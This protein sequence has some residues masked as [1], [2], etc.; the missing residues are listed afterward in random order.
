MTEIPRLS[1][2][3]K[4]VLDLLINNGEMYGLELV[5]ASPEIKRGA[6]YVMLNRMEEK[7]FVS[8]R[9][10]ENEKL[11]GKKR[12]RYSITGLGRKVLDL[13]SMTELAFFSWKESLT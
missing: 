10:F 6:I 9:F 3:E 5:N 8:S 7:G 11:P 2:K 4:I 1:S 12:P 13:Q